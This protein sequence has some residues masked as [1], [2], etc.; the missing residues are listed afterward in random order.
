[1]TSHDFRYEIQI[2]FLKMFIAIVLLMS[3]IA[4]LFFIEASA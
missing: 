3:S 1:M 4:A 2:H